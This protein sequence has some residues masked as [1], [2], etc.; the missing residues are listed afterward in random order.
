[1]VFGCVPSVLDGSE[2]IFSR[3]EEQRLPAK[4]G[5]KQFL[6]KIVNQCDR[7]ICV[8][9]SVGTYLNWREN[10][11]TGSKKDNRIDY[12]EIY[13]SKVIEGEGMT[14]KEAFAYLRHHGVKSK[15]GNLTISEYAMIKN[16]HSLRLA[17]FMNGPCVGALPVYNFSKEFWKKGEGDVFQGYHAISIVGYDD[18]GFIIRNSWGTAFGD[19]GY[20]KISNEDIRKFVEI[21]TVLE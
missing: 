17:I 16:E 12:E 20:T 8:P 21:W 15:I 18:N 19:S 5:Y 9:C 4:Y 6:P 14:F 13:A 10:L 2:H 1:M 11:N 7:P 3:S